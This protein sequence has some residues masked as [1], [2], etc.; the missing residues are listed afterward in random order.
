M[1]RLL[2]DSQLSQRKADPPARQSPKQRP[3]KGTDRPGKSAVSTVETTTVSRLLGRPVTST[4][5]ERHSDW[6]GVSCVMTVLSRCRAR[7]LWL[8][9]IS[10]LRLPATCFGR[11]GG[12]RG[13]RRQS[14]T[15][16]PGNKSNL[17]R[18]W[19]HHVYWRTAPDPIAIAGSGTIS[20]FEY[21][22]RQRSLASSRTSLYY[23]SCLSSG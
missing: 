19:T 6:S 8:S 5:T 23:Q 22:K 9:G 2:G 7:P 13:P 11:W 18:C 3:S 10:S 4:R 12:Y 20:G 14:S 1:Y 21:K 15:P 16:G 17:P